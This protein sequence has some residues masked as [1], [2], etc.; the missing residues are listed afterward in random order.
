MTLTRRGLFAALAALLGGP[1]GLAAQASPY[2]PLDDPGLPL[3]EHLIVRGDIR[4][5]S[6]MVRPFRRADL[7]RE[8]LA[9]DSAGRGDSAQLARLADM[10]DDLPEANRWR[11]SVRVGG[12]AYTHARRDPWH[13]AGPDGAR[14]Y[15]E[16]DLQ[17]VIGNL[18]LATRPVLEPRLIVDPDWPGRKDLDVAGRQAESYISGQFGLARLLYGQLDQNWG[19]AGVPGISLSNYGY[20]RPVLGLEVG[21][22]AIRLSAQAAQLTDERD[23]ANQVVH[24]Y[25][26]AHRLAAR[27]SSRLHVALWET[28]VFAGASRNAD[29]RQLSPL[30]L[31]FLQ[32]AY[33]LGAETNSMLG[34]DVLW[35]VS[36]RLTLQGQFA[37]DDLTYKDRG[38]PTRNP[39]RWAFTL[40][41][42]GPLAR[43][44]AWRAWYTQASSLAFR[45]FD[46][47]FQDFTDDGVGIGR[48]FADNDQLVVTVTLP[49]AR[50]WL[51]APEVGMLRQGEGR[52][53]DPYPTSGSGELGS[54][55][56][57][58]IGV[59]E[60]TWRAG[61]GI[62]GALRPFRVN[63]SAGFHHIENQNHIEGATAN[64][65]EG[66]LFITVGTSRRGKLP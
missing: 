49:V 10:Y 46:N 50:G 34:A 48:N 54:T 5:P 61:L 26:F 16:V 15:G 32:N 7:R 33:G 64:R 1:A 44:Y 60:R 11:A 28:V 62:S 14:P 23:S 43:R 6:P 63:A 59:V 36:R 35:N 22:P 51:L 17:A 24:R 42:S 4:D 21:T 19:P 53:Q 8:L 38:S 58:F 31:S 45:T 47:Q 56:Q 66:R 13:P 37:L 25:F 9:S 18:V 3:V 12:Q 27:V 39:D 41:G 57:L 52:I 55:P 29:F 65:F 20:G 2:I 40:M 30:S